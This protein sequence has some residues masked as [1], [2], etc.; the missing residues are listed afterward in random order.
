[1]SETFSRADRRA[2]LVVRLNTSRPVEVSDL[3]RSFQ[4]LGKQYEEFVVAHGYDQT[5]GNAQLFV[6]HLETGSIVATLQT[7]LDQAPFVLK[8]VDVM[9]RFVTNLQDILNY[10]LFQD[11]AAKPDKLT[12]PDAER[13]ISI[14]EPVTPK[15]AFYSARNFGQSCPKSKAL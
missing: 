9:A 15:R 2:E 1:M 4:A 12:K 10:F 11:T 3:G 13:V 6:T 14:L 5:P 7:M 8:H